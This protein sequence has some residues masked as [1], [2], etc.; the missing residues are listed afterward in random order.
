[1]PTA[2]AQ[3]TRTAG[4]STPAEFTVVCLCAEWC[5][6]C[7]EYRDGFRDIAGQFPLARF[8]WLDIEEHADDLGDIDVEN[9]PT[10]LIRR[11]ELIVF[12]GTI[13][14]TPSHLRR[15]LE[16]LLAQSDDESRHHAFASDERQ[17]W[18][19]DE[20]LRRLDGERL[21]QLGLPP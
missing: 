18:Q 11:R 6:V 15:M 14:P 16:V 19:E 3:G 7:R 21:R 17:S 12:Y 4:T 20:D 5:G 2:D 13:L 1:M 8:H 9:F 10:L